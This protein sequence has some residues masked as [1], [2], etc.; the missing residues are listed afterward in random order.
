MTPG[1]GKQLNIKIFFNFSEGEFLF[2]P[3]SLVHFLANPLRVHCRLTL[4]TIRKTKQNKNGRTPELQFP[5][6]MWYNLILD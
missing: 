5:G 3:N 2:T 1:K 4:L 6:Y